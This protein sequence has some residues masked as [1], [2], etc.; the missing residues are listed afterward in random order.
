MES[1]TFVSAFFCDFV[2]GA[3]KFYLRFIVVYSKIVLYVLF[4]LSCTTFQFR[5]VC[6]HSTILLYVFLIISCTTLQF[7]FVCRLFGLF[8]C[9]NTNNP[10]PCNTNVIFFIHYFPRPDTPQ[11]P[12]VVILFLPP[13]TICWSACTALYPLSPPN[14]SRLPSLTL[15]AILEPTC[16]YLWA[17]PFFIIK[18]I[19]SDSSSDPP[20]Q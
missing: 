16:Q 15:Q 4:I 19:L 7:G 1:S 5:F 2:L 6:S 18:L 8:W 17:T 3:F 12:I 9:S 14:W 13:A 10:L 20:K 11:K